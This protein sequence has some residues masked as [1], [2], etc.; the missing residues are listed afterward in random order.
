VTSLNV[1]SYLFVHCESGTGISSRNFDKTYRLTEKTKYRSASLK[2]STTM[3][4]HAEA[5]RSDP[6]TSNGTFSAM[7]RPGCYELLSRM[8]IR[9]TDGLVADRSKGDE[10]FGRLWKLHTETTRFYHTAVHLEEML[11]FF[12]VLEERGCMSGV[13]ETERQ[14]I[15]LSIFFHDA[16]YESR[17]RS[18]EENSAQLFQEFCRDIKSPDAVVNT[19]VD[20]FILATKTHMTSDNHTVA[21]A[22]FLDLDMAVLGKHLES[23]ISYASMI[24][25]EYDFIPHDTYCQKRAD[26]LEAFMGNRVFGTKVMYDAFEERAKENVRYEV[27]LLRAGSIP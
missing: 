22:T 13:S 25:R 7:N 17:S 5:L 10:W 15:L 3:D 19:L 8:W 9:A 1:C 26:V 14:A 18:N 20:E 12:R 2:N 21:L 4:A 27:D 24:R 11:H 16:I 6:Y 23:Y